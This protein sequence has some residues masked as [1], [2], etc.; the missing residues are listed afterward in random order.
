MEHF[1]LLEILEIK[2]SY[3]KVKEKVK[4][5]SNILPR[6]NSPSSLPA[7]PKNVTQKISSIWPRKSDPLIY[8]WNLRFFETKLLFFHPPSIYKFFFHKKNAKRNFLNHLKQNILSSHWYT[9]RMIIYLT[10]LYSKSLEVLWSNIK[11][12][13]T[14][15]R[16]LVYSENNTK[17]TNREWQEKSREIQEE[18]NKKIF[19]FV[20]IKNLIILYSYILNRFCLKLLLFSTQICMFVTWMSW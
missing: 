13:C 7:I 16:Q 5:K 10:K 3:G 12:S 18:K 2:I 17:N 20:E 11:H 14:I 15:S 4:I 19:F 8:T 1:S 6:L 9:I